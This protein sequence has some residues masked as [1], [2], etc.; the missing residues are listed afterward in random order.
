MLKIRERTLPAGWYPVNGV[1]IAEYAGSAEPGNGV[2][3]AVAG[4]SPHAGWAFCGRMI[5]DVVRR[6]R[7]D[8][9]TVVVLG[10]HNPAG[11]PFFRYDDDAWDLPTGRLRRDVELADAAEEALPEGLDVRPERAVDNTVEVIMPMVASVRPEVSWAAWRVPADEGAIAFGEALAD[12]AKALGRTV[13]VIGSTDLTHY[14]PNYGHMPPESLGNPVEWV[15]ER[16]AAFLDAL[17]REDAREAL[18]LASVEM[19]ACS[20]G[21]AVAAMSFARSSGCRTGRLL[22]YATSRD[23]HPSSSFVGYGTVVW[24]A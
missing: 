18:R 4:V 1:E 7:R 23:V 11:M 3:N 8:A 22:A 12:A 19:S 5:A 9:G 10:G 24:E 17:A 20:A 13:A 2:G 16:D 15:R 14:G 6:L 21:G